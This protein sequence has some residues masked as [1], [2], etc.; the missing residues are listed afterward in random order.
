MQLFFRFIT[1]ISFNASNVIKTLEVS[2]RKIG[3]LL[4]IF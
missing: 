3:E 4:Q 2:V 1:K